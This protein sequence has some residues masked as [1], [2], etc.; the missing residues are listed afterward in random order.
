V[1]S[2]VKHHNPQHIMGS[3]PPTNENLNSFQET[4]LPTLH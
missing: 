3:Y 1:E 2:G 4:F